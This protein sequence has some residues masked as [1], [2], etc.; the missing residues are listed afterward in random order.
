MN[1]DTNT[2]LVVDLPYLC[3]SIRNAAQ[4]AEIANKDLSVKMIESIV[5]WL[6]NDENSLMRSV[7]AYAPFDKPPFNGLVDGLSKIGCRTCLL[8]DSGQTK[9]PVQ[10]AVDL[11]GMQSI[12]RICII[13]GTCSI[14]PLIC[15]LM[16]SGKDVWI[17]GQE[18]SI[19][20]DLLTTVPDDC[21]VDIF[22]P[23]F[24]FV[25]AV[26]KGDDQNRIESGVNRLGPN[27]AQVR[28][29]S[30]GIRTASNLCDFGHNQAL[31]DKVMD[32]MKSVLARS[33]G[34][35]VWLGP[36]LRNHG[37]ANKYNLT[38]N[39]IKDGMKNLELQGSIRI[40]RKQNQDGSEYSV[41]LVLEKTVI[42][43]TDKIET[44]KI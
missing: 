4:T 43:S 29:D 27:E 6:Q 32:L 21:F 25:S 37:R 2:A 20:E 17:M 38:G 28:Q 11:C 3:Q 40:E 36:F 35:E 19:S 8:T 22:D 12:D 39:E 23:E 9:I 34:D 16:T 10:M 30:R 26:G 44:A 1:V 24:G 13:S 31:A 33:K 41:A 15:S 14:V 42:N 5:Q 7:I 18:T